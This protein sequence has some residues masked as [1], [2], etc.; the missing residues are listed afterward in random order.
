LFEC[1]GGWVK[2]DH[3]CEVVRCLAMR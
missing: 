2:D 3:A 1:L